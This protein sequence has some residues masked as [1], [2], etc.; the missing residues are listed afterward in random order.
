MENFFNKQTDSYWFWGPLVSLRPPKNEKMGANISLLVVVGSGFAGLVTGIV[1]L[2]L[3]VLFDTGF[4]SGQSSLALV[5]NAF[6]AVVHLLATPSWLIGC[7]LVLPTLAFLVWWPYLHFWNKRAERL[8]REAEMAAPRT[9]APGVWP[10][11]PTVG[12]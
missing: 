8:N 5:A 1:C 12:E 4:F 11:P 3:L 7:L 9:A 6:L 2:M 10:P